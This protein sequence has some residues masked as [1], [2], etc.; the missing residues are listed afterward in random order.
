M[1][2]QDKRSADQDKVVQA[3]VREGIDAGKPVY[4]QVTSG[5]MSPF[6]RAGDRVQ[7]RKA[8]WDE[9]RPGDILFFASPEGT[10]VTH[11]CIG[12]FREGE[13]AFILT[14]GDRSILPDSPWAHANL[15]GRV[16]SIHREKRGLR[17]DR[18]WGKR[19]N[20]VVQELVLWEQSWLSRLP[21]KGC[22]W[23]F[24]RFV[25]GAIHLVTWL[26]WRRWVPD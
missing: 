1:D 8:G 14:K 26:A 11:R 20:H 4:S 3:A 16:T 21:G 18:G 9:L 10:L 25:L 2:F 17:I 15:I 6:I 5:S 19:M 23:T 7:V 13:L 22:R 24:H 12:V